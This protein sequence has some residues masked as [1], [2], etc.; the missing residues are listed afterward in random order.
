M[1]HTSLAPAHTSPQKCPS[2]VFVVVPVG[3]SRVPTD[4]LNSFGGAPAQIANPGTS[5]VL[6]VSPKLSRG[7][8]LAL[9]SSF[10]DPTVGR[11]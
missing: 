6:H 9:F 11:V 3:L 2:S 5:T 1:T 7:K 4:R 10:L 8:Q